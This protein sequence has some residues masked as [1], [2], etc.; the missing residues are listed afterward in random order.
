MKFIFAKMLFIAILVKINFKF[1]MVYLYWSD[2][3]KYVNRLGYCLLYIFM[4]VLPLLPADGKYKIK[5]ISYADLILFIFFLFYI[6]KTV[7][8]SECR[9]KFVN[10]FL[11][12]IKS[13]IGIFMILLCIVMVASKFYA[14]DKVIAMS[15]TKRFI[16][17]VVLFFII[18]YDID[19]LKIADNIIGTYIL[20]TSILSVLGIYQFFTG[21]ALNKK[22]AQGYSFG[23]KARMAS[24]LDNPNTFA[25]FIIL[26]IFPILM[27]AIYAK[28]KV[29]K[30]FFSVL[31]V[32]LIINMFLTQSR[33]SY[34]AIAIG[35]I[36]LIIV[37]NKKLIIPFA[38]VV[39]VSF[40]IPAVRARIFEIGARSQ[41]LSRI[42]IWQIALKMIKE[43][44]LLGVGNGN[45][46]SLYD[47]Y[48]KKYPKLSWPDYH[49]MPA[50]NSYLKVW[51]ELGVLGIVSFL[52][53]LICALLKV[54]KFVIISD[55]SKFKYFFTGFYA[56]MIAFYFMNISD[57]LFFV[58]KMT[59]YF[60]IMLGLVQ[61]MLY[62]LERK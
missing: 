55:K 28:N 20:V 52:G 29:K 14:F 12:F 1:Q 47:A 26:A 57:T 19:D 22:F 41:D 54:R 23:V 7:V 11:D 58:P 27:Y 17:Y 21:F 15:E 56:S 59:A 46:V 6:I 32:L 44:P 60:W 5:G 53:I 30:A 37:Y 45:Y 40:I 35:F 4:I 51:S 36:V 34:L 39:V 50:H 16:S 38:G 3:M 2:Y 49:N 62:K 61:S 42:R 24:T 31:V 13:G 10:G 9:Q 33:N 48:V 18:K 43:H 25:A 8:N